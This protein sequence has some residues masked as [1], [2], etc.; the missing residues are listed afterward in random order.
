MR[1]SRK[2]GAYLDGLD[3]PEQREEGT[4]ALLDALG[5]ELSR[6]PAKD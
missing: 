6:E 1:R 4:G 3:V 5:A 2:Q